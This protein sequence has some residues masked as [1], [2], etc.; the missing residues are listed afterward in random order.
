MSSLFFLILSFF[1]LFSESCIWYLP[2]FICYPVDPSPIQKANLFA[3]NSFRKV[4]SLPL[5]KIFVYFDIYIIYRRFY[6]TK[7][8]TSI[9]YIKHKSQIAIVSSSWDVDF[10][11]KINVSHMKRYGAKKQYIFPRFSLLSSHSQVLLDFD[12]N[13]LMNVF[14]LFNCFVLFLFTNYLLFYLTRTAERK[15]HQEPQTV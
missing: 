5:L 15:A 8:V 12:K 13:S 14:C 3:S 4:I 9:K 2:R 11:K 6:T 7:P 1:N 10:H